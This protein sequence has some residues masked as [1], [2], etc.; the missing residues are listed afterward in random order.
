VLKLDTDSVGLSS[1]TFMLLAP[2]LPNR[3]TLFKVIQSH[4]F[5][6]NRKSICDFLLV[7]NANFHFV[8]LLQIISQICAFHRGYLTLHIHW[9]STQKLRTTKFG[10]KKLSCGGKCISIS[11]NSLVVAYECDRRTDRTAVSN[12]AV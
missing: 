9:G 1:T 7:I 2:K 10:L 11:W 5:G 8:S 3:V 6:T 12:S 4:L